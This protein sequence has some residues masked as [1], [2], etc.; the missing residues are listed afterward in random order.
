ME[1][2]LLL[3]WMAGFIDGEGSI[4]LNR[5]YDKRK[6]VR[7]FTYRPALQIVNT[8]EESIRRFY[9]YVGIGDLRMIDRISRN[10]THQANYRYVL[11]SRE[12][13]LKFLK[14]I[15]PYLLI[16]KRRAKLLIEYIENRLSNPGRGRYNPKTERDNEIWGELMLLNLRG[17]QARVFKGQL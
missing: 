10:K 14:E 5:E 16:K 9:D 13:L 15:Y 1:S 4:G 6:G 3:A 11:R 7:Y 12:P 8:N 2:K 17:I